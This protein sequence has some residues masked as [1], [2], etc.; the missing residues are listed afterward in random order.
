M[1]P[2]VWGARIYLLESL[3]TALAGLLFHFGLAHL[4]LSIAGI[5]AGALAWAAALFT[6]PEEDRSWRWTAHTLRVL[7]LLA[8]AYLIPGHPL[9]GSRFFS[10]RAPG[11]Q[12]H[13]QVSSAHAALA[14][15]SRGDQVLISANG[16][17]VC[18]NQEGAA[19]EELI[20]TSLL[21]H[22]SPRRVL[23]ISGGLSGG[24]AEA[25]KHAVERI[26]Y[27]ELDPALLELARK[28]G[29]ASVQRVLDDPRVQLKIADGRQVVAQQRG[30]YD[31]ILVGVPGPASALANRFFTEEFFHS[32]RAALR[33]GGIIRLV[34]AGS[35]GYLTAQQALT[36][37][38]VVHA[39]EGVMNNSV[40]LPGGTTLLLAGRDD[41]PE[42]SAPRLIE[43]LRSRRLALEHFGETEL[44]ARVLPF[45]REQVREHLARV[46]PLPNRD[47]HPAAYFHESLSWIALS[48][49]GL[50]GQM[51][52]L[53]Q[54]AQQ[55]VE[56]H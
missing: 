40:I 14:V 8:L 51:V 19:T 37:A 41:A 53:A 16:Q 24:L 48:A 6:G 17:L 7:S 21:V 31:V 28:F 42:V 4:P 2:A 11:Y 47:L 39:L 56:D 13:A 18:S 9:P 49:P 20:H 55:G 22:P 43:R 12:L 34:L 15:L 32:A 30:E 35:E 54:R 10:P 45:K 3:G 50:S 46:Q 5:A 25:L 26:D 1:S 44:M 38:T 23:M 52:R 29:G 27:V 33:P 36:H